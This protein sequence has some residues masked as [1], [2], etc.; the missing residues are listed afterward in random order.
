MS[1]GSAG[2]APTNWSVSVGSITGLTTTILAPSRVAVGATT[3]PAFNFSISG[4]PGG[5]GTKV[6][7]LT[8]QSN[9]TMAPVTVATYTLS[10]YTQ[11]TSGALT[12]ISS[13]TLDGDGDTSAFAYV[14]T[15]FAI[16]ATP[17]AS[18]TR[19]SA[20]AA[21]ASTTTLAH[22]YLTLFVTQGTNIPGATIVFAGP[23]LELGSSASAFQQTPIIDTSQFG[24]FCLP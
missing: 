17:G 21:F 6:F 22:V 19:F 13:V 24:V 11:L 15:P 2:V 18:L 3:I 14:S 5:S 12:G 8:D 10:C 9:A 4:T 7:I 23:Q 16:T 1:G 20:S